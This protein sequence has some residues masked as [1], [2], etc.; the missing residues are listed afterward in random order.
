ML[1]IFNNVRC[2][3]RPLEILAHYSKSDALI[4]YIFS[5][6]N[7]LHLISSWI[8][9]G[10]YKK[11][12][13]LFSL[14]CRWKAYIIGLSNGMGWKSIFISNFPLNVIINSPL[15]TPTTLEFIDNPIAETELNCHTSLGY[16]HLNVEFLL[17][18]PLNI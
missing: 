10:S 14:T 13:T 4:D 8:Y 16:I 18:S 17:S 15:F 2:L 12:C 7:P 5:I 6:W 3:Y 1:I 11:D 9:P